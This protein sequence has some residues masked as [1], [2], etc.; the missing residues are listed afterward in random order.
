LGHA[1]LVGDDLLGA[2]RDAGGLLGGQGERLVHGVGVQALRAAEHAG[3]RLDRHVRAML[4]S[5]CWAVSDTPAV[6]VWNRSC[7]DRSSS[8]RSG[9]HPAGPDAAGGAELADLFEEVDVGVEE[10]RQPGGEV[11]DVE[12]GGERQLDVGEAVGER[13][14]QL[15]GGG[16]ARLA[17]VVARDRDRVPARHLGGGERDGVGTSRIDGRGGKMNSFW[18]WYSFRMSFWSVP[19][20]GCGSTPAFSAWRRTSPSGSRPGR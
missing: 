15:L 19:P 1:G 5:G 2:Q 6:W 14:R 16:R 3:E 20:S 8:R 13:E 7:I 10:E 17:D 11:V 9:P 12:A 18:A 4:T